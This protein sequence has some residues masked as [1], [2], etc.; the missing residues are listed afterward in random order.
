MQ[1]GKRINSVHHPYALT[2]TQVRLKKTDRPWAYPHGRS[3]FHNAQELEE[4]EGAVGEFAERGGD[5]FVAAEA[6][7]ADGGVAK[8]G[9]VLRGV[10]ELYLAL[11]LAERHVADPV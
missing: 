8:R 5:F 7:Q 9:Q 3:V 4:F 2:S 6:E 11:V 10:S 1:L